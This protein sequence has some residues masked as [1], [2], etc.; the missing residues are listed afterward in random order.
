MKIPFLAVAGG[1]LLPVVA[2]SPHNLHALVQHATISDP[3]V[4]IVG[5]YFF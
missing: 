4:S 3:F 2:E 1:F 5:A